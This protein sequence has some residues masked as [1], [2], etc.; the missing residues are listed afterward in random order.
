VI[1]YG[2]DNNIGVIW[3]GGEV[4]RNGKNLA[5]KASAGASQT[6]S[7]E[8]IDVDDDGNDKSVA[9]DIYPD[10]EEAEDWSQPYAPVLK[11]SSIRTGAKVLAVSVPPVSSTEAAPA[12]LSSTIFVAAACSDN[13]TRILRIALDPFADSRATLAVIPLHSGQLV[14]VA[15]TWLDQSNLLAASALNVARGVIRFTQVPAGAGFTGNPD[16]SKKAYEEKKVCLE[17]RA[18]HISFNP[19][20]SETRHTQLLIVGAA[21][22][23]SVYD[24]QAIPKRQIRYVADEERPMVQGMFVESFST[25]FKPAQS[26]ETSAPSLALRKRIVNADW[27]IDG[28]AIFVLLASGEWGV[29][30]LGGAAPNAKGS[31]SWSDDFALHGI[32]G[33]PSSIPSASPEAKKPRGSRSSLA[34]A[35][36][37]TRRQKQADLFSGGIRT[38][39]NAIS[40]AGL[41]IQGLPSRGGGRTEYAVTIWYGDQIFGTPSLQAFWTR[42]AKDSLG[43]GSLDGPGLAFVEGLE[44]YGERITSVNRLPRSQKDFVVTGEH[45]LV[46][47]EMERPPTDLVGVA[48]APTATEQTRT[49]QLR[50]ARGDLDI[51]GLDRMLD[52]M[53]AS[54]DEDVLMI[55]ESPG[56]RPRR[57]D[58]AS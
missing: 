15:L 41:A 58:F 57:V 11:E 30:D 52:Q 39:G 22:S 3:R 54:A 2:T 5:S 25:P 32:I 29:W 36:P 43:G 12:F 50:L 16:P 53:G 33:G 21:S 55:D 10:A 51:G 31:S 18:S 40:N 24:P 48:A 8:I 26:G 38:I 23:V 35:T 7:I 4:K 45:R 27:A 1:V 44:L 13:T 20:P 46:F 14:S 37:N 47:L 56:K 34:P 42:A 17:N 19:S 9:D 6:N 49:D 28:K